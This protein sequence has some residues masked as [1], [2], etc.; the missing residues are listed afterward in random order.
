MTNKLKDG[1]VRLQLSIPIEVNMML[2]K[3]TP[4]KGDISGTIT[5]LIKEKYGKEETCGNLNQ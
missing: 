4:K 3:H 1:N 2:R 5:H